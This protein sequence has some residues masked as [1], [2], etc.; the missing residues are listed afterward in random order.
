MVTTSE[1]VKLPVRVNVKAPGS[2]PA[3]EALASVG[4]TVT[5]GSGAVSSLMITPTAWPSA[6]VAFALAFDRLTKNCSSGSNAV[7]PRMVT[8]TVLLVWPGVYVR[9][10]GPLAT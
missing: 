2:W 8:V 1:F 7:S 5:T 10:R 3:S 4:T 6:I 9:T